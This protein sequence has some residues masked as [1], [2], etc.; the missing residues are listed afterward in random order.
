MGVKG[1]P[2]A[3]EV[4]K[5]RLLEAF[6]VPTEAMDEDS[7]SSDYTLQTQVPVSCD[8]IID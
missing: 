4:D 2:N 6:C 5:A 1:S 3:A 8:V 7:D